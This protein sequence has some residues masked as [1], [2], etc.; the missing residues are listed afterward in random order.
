MNPILTSQ[1]LPLHRFFLSTCLLFLL[2]FPF[3]SI[4]V[5]IATGNNIPFLATGAGHGYSTTFGGCQN[6]LEI[7]LGYFKRV[8]V[9]KEDNKLT[10]GG[11]VTFAEIVDPLY[12]AGKEIRTFVIN[13]AYF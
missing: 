5:K 10:I 7:D 11:S 6:G 13:S 9:D 8:E 12:S 2:K 4:K 1:S 3:N